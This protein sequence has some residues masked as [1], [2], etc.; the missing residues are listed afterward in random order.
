VFAAGLN[1]QP[2]GELLGACSWSEHP[3]L[4][5]VTD[6]QA[7]YH[8]YWVDLRA[9]GSG[10][11]PAIATSKNVP[12][13]VAWKFIRKWLKTIGL[14][15]HDYTPEDDRRRGVPAHYRDG[16]VVFKDAI[17]SSSGTGTPMTDSLT[18]QLGLLSMLPMEERLPAAFDIIHSHFP[19]HLSYFS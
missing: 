17:K 2:I 1:A 13:L 14:P 19:P 15:K 7:G 11:K 3:V 9:P 16:F 4:L 5:V 18:D 10:V 12:P 8:L 6:L